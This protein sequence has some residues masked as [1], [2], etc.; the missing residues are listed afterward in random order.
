[1]SGMSLE[2]GGSED[3]D[4]N[5]NWSVAERR[6]DDQTSEVCEDDIHRIFLRSLLSPHD[7]VPGCDLANTK[8]GLDDI[9][10]DSIYCIGKIG[11]LTAKNGLED[12][13]RD[14]VSIF[15]DF[16][17]IFQQNNWGVNSLIGY[18]IE[19][20]KLSSPQLVD[21]VIIT[22]QTSMMTKDGDSATTTRLISRFKK[23]FRIAVKKYKNNK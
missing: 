19:I 4:V 14:I 2:R 23:Q 13:T 8:E 21:T 1:M 6:I 5:P 22:H 10:K 15:C 3:G 9:V 20:H 12:I 18:L 11:T 7:K 16:S 17:I